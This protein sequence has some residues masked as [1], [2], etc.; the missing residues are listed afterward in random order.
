MPRLDSI[1]SSSLCLSISSPL[2]CPPSFKKVLICDS[3]LLSFLL[4]PAKDH[5]RDSIQQLLLTLLVHKLSLLELL[6]FNFFSYP[7][8]CNVRIVIKLAMNPLSPFNHTSPRPQLRVYLYRHLYRENMMPNQGEIQSTTLSW[9]LYEVIRC[10]CPLFFFWF[11]FIPFFL[12]LP[13]SFLVLLS[14]CQFVLAE[15]DD[16]GS[17]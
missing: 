14:L 15:A 1:P 16:E 13:L 10:L 17:L 12:R 5:F 8:P 6:K 11:F 7:Y 2:P 9:D 4:L 3:H